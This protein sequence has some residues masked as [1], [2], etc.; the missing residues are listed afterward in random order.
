[1]AAA[2]AIAG[3][4]LVIDVLGL[5]VTSLLFLFFLWAVIDRQPPVRALVIAAVGAGATWLLFDVILRVRFPRGPLG[6]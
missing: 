1:M 3:C 5:L 2:V 4:G 6:L